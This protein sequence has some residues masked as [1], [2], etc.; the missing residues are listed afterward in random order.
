MLICNAT[1]FH[2]THAILALQHGK[3]VLV[4]KPLGLCYRDLDDLEA[5]ERAS[6]GRLFVGYMRR[7]APAFLNALAEV[8]GIDKVVYARVRDIIGHNEDFVCESGTFPKKFSD[9]PQADVEELS[10]IDKD[11]MQTALLSEF[12]VP[13]NDHTTRVLAMLSGL[14]SHDL[15]AMREALGMPESVVA[16]VLNFPI[17]TATFQYPSFPV[18]YESGII[19]VPTFDAHFEIYTQD[20]IVRV[21]YDTPYVKGLPITVTVREK[22][23]NLRGEPCY[24]ERHVRPTYEDAYTIE[25]REWYNC[26]VAAKSIKTT[27]ADAR[28]DLDL[29]RMLMQKAFG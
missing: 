5:A 13:F 7:Y 26:I 1:A 15:S 14:G 28:Q 3:H 12:G 11:I 6:T 19:S 17:W 29:I 9:I 21:K 18:V 10:R 25:F 24:Q 4:E 16:A 23:T 20:K 27:I 8:G 2:T 22:T